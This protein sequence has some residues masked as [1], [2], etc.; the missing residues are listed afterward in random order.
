[1]NMPALQETLPYIL[2]KY[3][4]KKKSL[5]RLLPEKN[6]L[7]VT[8]MQESLQHHALGQTSRRKLIYRLHIQDCHT[9]NATQ[10][11]PAAQGARVLSVILN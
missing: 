4:E 6:Q 8:T 1:M 2:Q 11:H 3:G 10:H 7:T 9:A 5:K